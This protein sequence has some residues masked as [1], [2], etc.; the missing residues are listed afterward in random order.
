MINKD[1]IKPTFYTSDY[2]V[3]VNA[4]FQAV[5]N[6]PNFKQISSIR[7]TPPKGSM[8]YEYYQKQLE[9][10]RQAKS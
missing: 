8:E 2:I 3:K 9:R 5:R 1:K 4:V 6:L 7:F 10:E